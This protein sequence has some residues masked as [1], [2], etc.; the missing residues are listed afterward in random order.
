MDTH[1]S[2]TNLFAHH[3]S[4]K[5]KV[6]FKVQILYHKEYI[7]S[8]YIHLSG[9]MALVGVFIRGVVYYVQVERHG[10][11]VSGASGAQ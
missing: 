1:C 9:P 8:F 5:I 7:F 3:S 2:K 11:Y 10:A 6:Y 4:V